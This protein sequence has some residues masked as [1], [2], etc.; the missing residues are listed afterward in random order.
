MALDL[1][2]GRH[3]SELDSFSCLTD[4]MKLDDP[5]EVDHGRGL[6]PPVLEP[7]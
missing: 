4:P 2:E 6:F 3:R 7:A 5:N 1:G